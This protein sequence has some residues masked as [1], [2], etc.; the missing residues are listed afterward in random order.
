[1]NLSYRLNSWFGFFTFNHSYSPN[2]VKE[3]ICL[4][5]I[6]MTARII[7]TRW[8]KNNMAPPMLTFL[9]KYCQRCLWA[10]CPFCILRWRIDTFYMIS[11]SARFCH[12][13]RF[14]TP[15]SKFSRVF[16]IK[17][18][19]TPNYSIY[20]ARRTRELLAELTVRRGRS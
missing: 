19:A 16:V 20:K 5:H 6:T 7:S 13:Y 1:M 18:K 17:T 2:D 8:K 9:D 14:R 10:F 11:Q 4:R 15:I 3:S 12:F